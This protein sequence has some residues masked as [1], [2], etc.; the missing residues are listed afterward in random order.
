M[1]H[2]IV[3][4]RLSSTSSAADHEAIVDALCALPATIPELVGYDVHLDAGLGAENAH[5]SVAATFADEAGWRTYATH[6]DH[7]RVIHERIEPILATSL[8]TQYTD[9][10]RARFPIPHPPPERSSAMPSLLRRSRLLLLAALALAFAT[11]GCSSSNSAGGDGPSA[12][13]STTIPAAAGHVDDSVTTSMATASVD[14]CKGLSAE[15]VSAIVGFDV[16]GDGTAHD[17]GSGFVSCQF[18]A[19][20]NSDPSAGAT[21]VVGAESAV[22]L[23]AIRKTLADMSPDNPPTKVDVGDGGYL[24]A[25]PGFAELRANAGKVQVEVNIITPM[26]DSI[27][28]G[29]L[30]EKV[31]KRVVDDLS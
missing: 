19:P 27:D 10:R 21:V 2:H 5:I 8:R 28:L 23:A 11:S 13:A 14:P 12:D 30:A 7:L 9:D 25:S 22:E 17:N 15:Q 4:L 1:F 26:D 24:Q 31:A 6:P 18:K 3:L 29:P 20:L 16:E